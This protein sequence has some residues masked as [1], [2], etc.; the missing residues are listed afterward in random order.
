MLEIQC[1]HWRGQLE[2]F[3]LTTQGLKK[4]PAMRSI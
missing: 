2:E 4:S 3:P 1:V